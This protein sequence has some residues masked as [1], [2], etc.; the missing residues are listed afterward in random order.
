MYHSQAADRFI[1]YALDYLT[2]YDKDY[3]VV[4]N[5]VYNM[6]KLIDFL[7]MQDE[8]EHFAKCVYEKHKELMPNTADVSKIIKQHGKFRNAD[9]MY[10]VRK[11]GLLHTSPT[12]STLLINLKIWSSLCAIAFSS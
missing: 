3:S 10:I 4:Q 8:M 12:S 2:K 1:S 7:N 5:T 11:A 9:F 6:L